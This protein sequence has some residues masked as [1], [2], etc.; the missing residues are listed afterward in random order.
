M[1]RRSPRRHLGRRSLLGVAALFALGACAPSPPA[2]SGGC[3]L[4]A[5]LVPPSA[6]VAAGTVLATRTVTI[7]GTPRK[8]TLLRLPTADGRVTYAEWVPPAN[9]PASTPAPAVLVTMPYAG[10]D[11]TGEGVDQRWATA[12]PTGTCHLPDTDGPGG[13]PNAEPIA[14]RRM[15]PDLFAQQT[16]TVFVVNGVGVLGVFGRFYAG[17]SWWGYAQDM[18]AGMRYLGTRS[19]VD[20]KRIGVYGGSLGGYEAFYAAAYAP[21]S[22]APRAV[23]PMYAPAD[24]E[25][26]MTWALQTAPG[27]AKTQARKD[28]FAH[29]FD[30]YI[31]R[32]EVDTGG[33]PGKGD[34]SCF[35]PATL[36]PRLTGSVLLVQDTWDLL[37]DPSLAKALLGDLGTHGQILWYRHET[38]PDVDTLPLG[39]GPFDGMSGYP[40]YE[41]FAV[42]FLL[43]HLG[44]TGTLVV[45]DQA[46]VLS[47]LLTRWR[48]QSRAGVAQ[49][50]AAARLAS[51]A[52]PGVTLYDV[53]NGQ[54]TAGDQA[55]SAGLA[56]VWGVTVPASQVA[57]WLRTHG[58]P[59]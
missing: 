9:A 57:A 22:V 43:E 35:D 34:F 56:A 38:P 25:G 27:L 40:S 54:E 13:G 16:A 8:V 28:A 18:V 37:V 23:V 26:E 33:P 50:G 1:R 53:S 6:V 11:W 39:H 24:L 15:S 20:P 45:P 32:A 19:D 21:K 55:V 36:S 7:A 10:I 49:P 58:L 2:A 41:T 42:A 14:Y 46:T 3:P 30:P 5:R 48:D 29:F 59:P 51:L 31:R 17:G 52:D 44:R 12:C 4:E 47:A